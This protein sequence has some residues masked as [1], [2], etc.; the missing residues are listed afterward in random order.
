LRC[1]PVLTIGA[2]EI[3]AEHAEAVGERSG[4]G[5]EEWFLFDWVALSAGSVSPGDVE[6]AAAVVADFADSGLAFGDGTA[7]STSEAAHAIVVELLDERGIGF[8][9]LLV[10]NGAEGGHGELC[11]YSNAGGLLASSFAPA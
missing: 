6:R 11:L 1:Y 8:A 5:V 3:A 7:M 9:D 10:E 4:T 2:V